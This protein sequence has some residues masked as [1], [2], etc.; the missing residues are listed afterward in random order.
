MRLTSDQ[1]ADTLTRLGVR[2]GVADDW[3]EAFASAIGD[4][5]FSSPDDLPNFVAQVLHESGFLCRL[6]ENL[7]YSAER[8]AQ[9]WPN[10]FP[11]LSAAQPYAR[12]PRA[13]AN[14]VYGGRLGNTSPDDGWR[15]HGR[16]LIQLTGRANYAMAQ[17]LTG[18][19]LLDVPELLLEPEPALR[20]SV[21]WWEKSVPDDAL[22]DVRRVTRYVNGGANGLAE[23]ERLTARAR[24]VLSGVPA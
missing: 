8:L 13:L 23:R 22:N 9:V 18:M 20:A 1:W 3:A 7:N 19:A 17:D 6:D 15:Y 14:K 12:N 10:R 16:G 4:N 5:T 11:S 24:S 21:A 2:A